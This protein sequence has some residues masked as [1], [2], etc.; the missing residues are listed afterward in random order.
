MA[1]PRILVCAA[2]AT[3]FSTTLVA[4]MSSP[5]TTGYHSISC[6]KVVP[7]KGAEFT[8][9]MAEDIHKYA[10]S[11]VD[12]GAITAWLE[13]RTV[14]PAG[15]EAECDYVLVSFYPGLPNEPL[16]DAAL[17]AALHQAGLQMSAQEYSD[18]RSAL[19]TLVSNNITQYQVLVGGAH[20]GDYLVFNS[21]KVSDVGEWVA[22]E[23]KV[24]QPIAEAM[25]KEGVRTAWAVNVQIFPMGSQD[26]TLASTV[27]VYPTWASM[28]TDP[29]FDA[30]FKKVH[31]D[32]EFG[33]TFE[34]FQKLRTIESTVL[35]HVEDAV[36]K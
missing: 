32:M 11:R 25:V 36:S 34:H 8:K 2:L 22:Y 23:K 35:Y 4:Q 5:S 27:D 14:M 3:A 12:S 29:G 10:Q 24:W 16:S 1:I 28:F 15:S 33:T 13:L 17:T 31:P 21:M 6:I 30:R 20:K 7:G 18:R 9:F 19:S 26:K